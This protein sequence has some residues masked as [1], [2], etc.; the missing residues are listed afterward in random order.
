MAGSAIPEATAE[1]S[2]PR[3]DRGTS[4]SVRAQL[5]LRELLLSG[6]IAPGARLSELA[7]VER[8]GVSRTPVRAALTLLAEEGL[9][10]P[11]PSGG[12]AARAFSEQD[13]RDSIEMRGTLE[14]LAARLAA[15]R[16][17]SA[18]AAHTLQDL[19]ARLDEVVAGPLTG[20]DVFERYIALNAEW[21]RE[22]I[23]LAGSRVV[24]RQIERVMALPFASPSAFVM[25]Q[26]QTAEARRILTLA[27]DQHHAVVEAILQ[28]EG[29]RA[30]ALMREHS[31]LASR[32]LAN[33]ARSRQAMAQVPGGALIR[34]RPV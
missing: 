4:Q 30:E 14:G 2:R 20:P 32:N 25:A 5:A 11:I 18:L 21:H 26:A 12:F 1:T 3:E 13:V 22:I 29:A 15:E 31:R 23:G 8:I 27:Q 33:A 28:R 24:E 7:I 6:E 34:L 10:E 19:L 16:G 17:I 9:V